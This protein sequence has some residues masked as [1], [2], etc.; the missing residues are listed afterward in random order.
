MA[1]T[2]NVPIVIIVWKN[3]RDL[4]L[5]EK[6][7]FLS[8]DKFIIQKDS[9]ERLTDDEVI[10]DV[11]FAV[12]DCSQ[13]ISDDTLPFI[14][15]FSKMG[16]VI[17][18]GPVNFAIDYDALSFS[19]NEYMKEDKDKPNSKI[20]AKNILT[21]I[22]LLLNGQICMGCNWRNNRLIVAELFL[23][24]YENKII[25]ILT[26]EMAIVRRNSDKF[27][28]KQNTYIAD[29]VTISK[30][31]P[32]LP[33]L[34]ND[35][36]AIHGRDVKD[37]TELGPMSRKELEVNSKRANM[38]QMIG[39]STKNKSMWTDFYLTVDFWLAVF[40]CLSVWY[41]IYITPILKSIFD[42]DILRP[43]YMVSGY[44]A[45]MPLTFWL[46]KR[47]QAAVLRGKKPLR[48]RIEQ[49]I[50]NFGSNKIF[51]TIDLLQ[52]MIFITTVIFAPVWQ[53]NIT[54]SIV[55][56][57]Y[58]LIPQLPAFLIYV[59]SA[60]AS[61]VLFLKRHTLPKQIKILG[62]ILQ[63]IFLVSLLTINSVYMISSDEALSVNVVHLLILMLIPIFDIFLFWKSILKS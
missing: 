12:Y 60:I 22:K 16:I 14:V 21:T 1:N 49:S 53:L 33:I 17:N 54:G 18:I 30:D 35:E 63:V 8:L 37:I 19:Q 20:I 55:Q 29:K 28:I 48:Y 13:I 50:I 38:Q 5:R 40:I 6:S 15:S 43:I 24:G 32:L 27:T 3:L 4:L 34:F 41:V 25:P 44:L 59:M 11:P 10:D 23:R 2:E 61:G 47:K 56:P 58:E 46:L 42:S 36:F 45:V 39:G 9:F 7:P 26:A 57:A 62:I 51:W 31:Y 52:T